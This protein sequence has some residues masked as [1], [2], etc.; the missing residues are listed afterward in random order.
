MSYYAY[1][2]G[3]T[4][5]PFFH[6]IRDHISLIRKKRMETPISRHSGLHHGFDLSKINFFA[7]DHIPP[8]ERGGDID[9]KLLQLESKCIYL[10]QATR[11]PGLNERI[12][13]KPFI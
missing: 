7:L 5:R 3:K 9:K 13:Y 4:K 12:R 1:Y 6:K 10:L 8:H 11:Y 2:V